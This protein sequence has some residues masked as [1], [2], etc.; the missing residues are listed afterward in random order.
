MYIN[1]C[2]HFRIFAVKEKD[3]V[4]GTTPEAA[5]SILARGKFLLFK[6]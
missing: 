1:V 5:D 3:C 6:N 2:F 4:I